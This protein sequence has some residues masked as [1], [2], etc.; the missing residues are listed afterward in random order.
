M[1]IILSKVPT[2][3]MERVKRRQSRRE[4]LDSGEK[5]GE[6]T[7]ARLN[8]QVVVALTA[9]R[10]TEAQWVALMDRVYWLEDTQKNMGNL[11]RKF[12]RQSEAP[13]RGWLGFII[14]PTTE[15]YCRCLI[16][17]RLYQC[18]AVV[19]V[20]LSC[21][22]TWSEVTFFSEKPKLS[23]LAL[24]IQAGG[25]NRNYTAIEMISL[26]TV[27]YMCICAYYTIFKVRVLNYYYLAS[28]H[29]SDEYTLLFSGALLCRLTP[30]LCLNFLS[31]IHLD[32]HV[33]A[34]WDQET[35]YTRVMG[36]MDVVSIISNVF[37]IYFP[38]LLLLLTL[39]TY[40][41]LGSRLLSSL[42]FQQFLE[43]E[44]LTGELVE[45]GRELVQREKRR[46]ERLA[47]SQRNRRDWRER[48]ESVPTSSEARMRAA[49]MVTAREEKENCQLQD[50]VPN[51]SGTLDDLESERSRSSAG[52]PRNIFQDI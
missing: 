1:D 32:S 41:S 9:H 35:A 27:L 40:F 50:S 25:Y 19:A 45:E 39:A 42:G 2:E 30:P 44:E 37:N 8:K 23:L 14:N 3:L 5:V 26:A 29:Q 28:N 51:Y 6:Q 15:W 36:H 12:K 21:I 47:E 22:L 16:Q 13:D 7:L 43:Q 18:M 11:D 33:I 46:R 38:I 34:T 49:A 20:I 4:T 17:P 24:F 31:L 52:P 10:R 48:S